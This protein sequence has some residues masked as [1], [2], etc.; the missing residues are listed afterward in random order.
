MPRIPSPSDLRQRHPRAA[1]TATIAAPILGLTL[2]A[3]GLNFWPTLFAALHSIGSTLYTHVKPILLTT[4]GLAL[5]LAAIPYQRIGDLKPR[6]K[7]HA[8]TRFWLVLLPCVALSLAIIAWLPAWNVHRMGI[9]KPEDVI[10]HEETERKDTGALILS[11]FGTYGLYLTWRRAEAGDRTVKTMEQGHITDRYT[12]A[13]EQLGKMDGDKPNIEV[14]L[15]AIYALERIAWDSP[16]D[17]W[18]IM[19]VLTAYIRRNAPAPAGPTEPDPSIKPRTEIQAILDVLKRR[20]HAVERE[21]QRLSLTSADLRGANLEKAPLNRS[22]LGRSNLQM[23]NLEEAQL[24]GAGLYQAQLQGAWLNRAQ[25]QGA[26]LIEAQLQGAELNGASLQGARLY[27]A[28]LQGTILNGAQLQ[29]ARYLKVEQ[30]KTAIDWES[31]HYDPDFRRE[32]GLPDE[33]APPI[34]RMTQ[35]TSNT[36]HTDIRTPIPAPYG[37]AGYRRVPRASHASAT[38]KSPAVDQTE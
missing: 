13:I 4:A 2:I 33:P 8:Q 22:D 11:L 3:T 27:G 36:S 38:A 6:F 32:L 18:T 17:H 12:K 29:G 1:L 34:P 10:S 7:G 16:R 20:N 5:I 23:A 37:P 30:V 21:D 15:G 24:Q 25:L 14:R 9:T 31:A 35:P 28:S 26:I 19:E